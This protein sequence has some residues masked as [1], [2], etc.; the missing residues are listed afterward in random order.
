MF[1]PSHHLLQ[2]LVD[3]GRELAGLVQT[4]AQQT[5]DLL[6]HAVRGQESVVALG[7]SKEEGTQSIRGKPGQ[8]MC[9]GPRLSQFLH[10]MDRYG[11]LHAPSPSAL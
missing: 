9:G 3:G 5:R 6:D 8:R 11:L 2:L 4:R 7:C 1:M 10:S